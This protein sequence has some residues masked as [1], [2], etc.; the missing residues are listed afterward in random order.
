MVHYTKD[1]VLPAGVEVA[2]SLVSYRG[3]STR[4][5]VGIS[6]CSDSCVTIQPSAV[7][8]E[9]QQITTLSFFSHQLGCE[10]KTLQRLMR[11]IWGNVLV[12]QRISPVDR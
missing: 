6:N 10:I 12:K 11:S 1:T 3:T 2:P 8:C 9:L 7:L 5:E 4:V